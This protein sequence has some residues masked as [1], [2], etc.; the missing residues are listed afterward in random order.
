MREFYLIAYVMLPIFLM[1]VLGYY[2][3]RRKVIGAQGAKELNNI[4]FKYLL[5]VQLFMNIFTSD[6]QQALNWK[7]ISYCMALV[8]IVY[9]GL[10][11]VIPKMFPDKRKNVPMIHAMYRSNYVIFGL[12]VVGGFYPD[13]VAVASVV[14][15]FVVP[16]YNVLGVVLL[17]K[18]GSLKKTLVGIAKNPLILASLLGVIFNLAKIALPEILI[19]FL[20]DIVKMTNPLALLAVGMRFEF[21]S[22]KDNLKPML[23]TLAFRLVLLPVVATVGGILLGFTNVELMT[24]LIMFGS[25][26]A[27]ATYTLSLG[28]DVDH[29]LANLLVVSCTLCCV[30]TLFLLL[31]IF[32]HTPFMVF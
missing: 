18:G 16:V 15:A 11:I 12:V 9:V 2:L 22:I 30:I 20:N 28:Y 3:T 23:H 21:D 17:E 1:M 5:P 24:I 10:N 25:P 8:M 26:C 7:L 29:S 13:Q 27:V 4:V 19:K 31:M 6:L 32:S 14:A